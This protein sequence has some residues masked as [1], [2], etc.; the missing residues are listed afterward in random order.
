VHGREG[1]SKRG[2]SEL[3][4][5]AVRAGGIPGI[6]ELIIAGQHEMIK[7]EHTT[8]SRSVFAQG[9]LHAAEWLY[10]QSEPRIYTM[11]DLLSAS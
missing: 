10:R 6:H 9:A 3:E 2:G 7:I 11:D 1:L 5:L 4:V 8:F